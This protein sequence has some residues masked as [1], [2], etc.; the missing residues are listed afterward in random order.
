MYDLRCLHVAEVLDVL[1]NDLC[2]RFV[3][4]IRLIFFLLNLGLNRLEDNVFIAPMNVDPKAHVE[5]SLTI[6]VG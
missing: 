2:H 5:W 6:Y 1:E 3:G 4:H